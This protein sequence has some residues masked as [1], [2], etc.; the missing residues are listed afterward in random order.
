[1]ICKNKDCTH[2]TNNGFRT[3]RLCLMGL[4]PDVRIVEEEE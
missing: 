4:T 1:M 3:C 2:R